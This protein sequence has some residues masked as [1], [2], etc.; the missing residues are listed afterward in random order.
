MNRMLIFG[1]TFLLLLAF[2]SFAGDGKVNYSGTWNINEEKS[3]LGEGGRFFLSTKL[4]IVQKDNDMTM[5]RHRTGRNGEPR[6]STDKFTLD[7]KECENPAFGDNVRKSVV[8]WSDDGKSMTI[9]STMEFWREG[10]KTEFKSTEIYKLS[11][12]GN[13]LTIDYT[14]TSPRG[15]RKGTYIYDKEK[16]NG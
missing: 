4:V 11:D 2:I 15:E 14:N 3:E 1:I 9:N 6:S 8:T 7:G 12:D 16:T 10:N 13:V 5:E